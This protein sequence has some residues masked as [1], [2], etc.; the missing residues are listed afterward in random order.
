M[1][2]AIINPT[3]SGK[4]FF[5]TALSIE[6]NTPKTRIKMT[7]FFDMRLFSVG[8]QI[9]NFSFNLRF[10]FISFNRC[11]ATVFLF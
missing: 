4:I 2:D 11:Q 10:S 6:I 1:S 9:H 3:E 8:I 5:D 7:Y